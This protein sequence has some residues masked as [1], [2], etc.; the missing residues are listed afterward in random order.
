[1]RRAIY[2]LLICLF[3][4]LAFGIFLYFTYD[5]RPVRI[6]TQVVSCVTIGSLMM[7]VIYQRR[8]FL[9][10]VAHPGVRAAIMTAA[11]I[12][13]ALIGTEIILLLQTL[14]LPGAGYHFLQGGSVYILNILV[15]LVIGIPAYVSLEWQR[16]LENRISGQAY[17]ML[18]LE[19]QQAVFELELLRAKINPH[20]L[21][22]VHNTI[23]GLISKDP[24]K[25][26]TLVLLLS[27]FFRFTLHKNSATYHTVMDELDI[28]RTYLDM[29]QIRFERRMQ[30]TIDADP[31]TLSLQTA[32]FV[33][34]PLVE[35]AV[36][37]GIEA[38]AAGGVIDIK[39]RVAGAAMVITVADP[40]P[41]FPERPHTGAGLQ[42]VMNK[43]KLLYADDY[44]LTFNNTPEK[45][46]QLTVPIHHQNVV[47]G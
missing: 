3:T 40:G 8:Y 33:L 9:L 35:N 45:Y 23:A 26:E 47:G 44:S 46:V 21:Y 31:G 2:T 25:A 30:Y 19:R 34:Q 41:A 38:R 29:Q 24:G 16:S 36:K 43:L 17:R 13:T 28:V 32:S 22:N 11:L 37:H 12:L 10:T 6:L 42:L 27:K 4:G 20:F 7:L 39:I 15:V 5:H 18:Q 1:M 14:Y